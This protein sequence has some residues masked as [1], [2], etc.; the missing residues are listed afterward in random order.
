MRSLVPTALLTLALAAVPAAPAHSQL[1]RGVAASETAGGTAWQAGQFC[2]AW[3]EPHS[4]WYAAHVTAVT[5]DSIRVEHFDG[6]D[7]TVV[8]AWVRDDFVAVGDT[9]GAY[10]VPDSQWYSAVVLERRGMEIVVEYSDG[11]QETTWLKQIRIF[12]AAPDAG[13]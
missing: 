8:P 1:P 5:P 7:D 12:E 6:Y 10:Y 13:G 2:W 9:V 11:E 3:Y 4:A